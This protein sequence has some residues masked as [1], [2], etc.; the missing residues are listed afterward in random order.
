MT[1]E[2]HKAKLKAVFVFGRY[3]TESSVDWDRDD[4]VQRKCLIQET[5][6]RD[7]SKLKISIKPCLYQ[8]TKFMF[9][10]FKNGCQ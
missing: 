7:E 8:Q 2:H 9:R 5:I 4:R 3:Q 1:S 10:T 6:L